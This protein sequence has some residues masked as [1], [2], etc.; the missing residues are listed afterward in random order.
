MKIKVEAPGRVNLI[1]E[2]TDYNGGYVLP[3]AINKKITFDISKSSSNN[4][5]VF[6]KS[7]NDSFFFKLKNI[8]K[9]K[10]HWQNY[11]LGSIDFFK[12][13]GHKLKEFR[14]NINSNLPIGSG[15]SSSSALISGFSRA[16]IEYNNLKYDKIDIVKIVSYVESKFIG[17]NGGIMDQFTINYGKKDHLILLNCTNSNYNY[18]KFKSDLYTILLLNTNVKHSLIDSAYNLRVKECKTAEKILNI[19]YNEIRRLANYSSDKLY[20]VKNKLN[21]KIYNRANFVIHE[22]KRTLNAA[23]LL[24]KSKFK[25]FGKL[26][27]KSHEGLKNLYEVSCPELDFIVDFT[28]DLKYVCGSRMMGGGFGGCTINLVEKKHLN[29]FIKLISKNYSENFNKK[30]S[31]IKV[32]IGDGVSWRRFT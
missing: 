28:K 30:L 24:K 18:I 16:I 8:K 22:N 29:S 6:S 1:G 23:D 3:G 20:R 31:S 26:M 12:L 14:C 15:I 19:H 10:T 32:C 5:E 7:F 27:Y 9:S 11:I 2:H 4:C 21:S 17:L 25:E 13:N